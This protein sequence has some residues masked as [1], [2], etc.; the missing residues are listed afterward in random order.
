MKSGLLKLSLVVAMAILFSGCAL[1]Y[2]LNQP[3][4]SDIRYDS[5]AEPPVVLKIVDQR[6]DIS[7]FKGIGGLAKFNIRLENVSDPIDW[8]AGRCRKSSPRGGR[9]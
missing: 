4:P 1:N 6:E 8:L 7:F 9:P 2:R 5:G 3:I